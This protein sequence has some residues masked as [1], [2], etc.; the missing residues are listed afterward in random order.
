[1]KVRPFFHWLKQVHIT[2]TYMSKHLYAAG[3]LPAVTGEYLGHGCFRHWPSWRWLQ[4][5]RCC[6]YGHLKRLVVWGKICL[7]TVIN[8]GALKGISTLICFVCDDVMTC[9][10]KEQFK[11]KCLF[12]FLQ[13]TAA[14]I[15]EF[16][17]M[18]AICHT[19]VPERTDG[20]IT[21]QA[22]SPG[23]SHLPEHSQRPLKICCLVISPVY[24]M[25]L[26]SVWGLKRK[27]QKTMTKHGW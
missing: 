6:V 1:M 16:M 9:F 10:F 7:R 13:P 25:T 20:K 27:K 15:Q 5:A 11:S 18:M 14:V 8:N 3:F 21:Y 19:A 23:R 24:D 12:H 17:T 26:F 22:A 2:L 4:T